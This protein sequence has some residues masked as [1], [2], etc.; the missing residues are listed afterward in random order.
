[1]SNVKHITKLGEYGTTHSVYTVYT[2]YGHTA[3]IRRLWRTLDDCGGPEAASILSRLERLGAA[4]REDI[5]RSPD[6]SPLI[7]RR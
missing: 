4:V 5:D 2:V 1:M 6:Y 3:E 7:N